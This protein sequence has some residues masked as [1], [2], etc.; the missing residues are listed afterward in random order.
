[1]IYMDFFINLFHICLYDLIYAYFCMLKPI[2][3]NSSYPFIPVYH[4][5]LYELNRSPLLHFCHF[6]LSIKDLQNL[7]KVWLL[8]FDSYIHIWISTFKKNTIEWRIKSTSKWHFSEE[9]NSAPYI[10]SFQ[11]FVKQYGWLRE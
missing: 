1:M 10:K 3:D 11:Q 6:L 5:I 2:S 4:T 7:K 8:Q 9:K